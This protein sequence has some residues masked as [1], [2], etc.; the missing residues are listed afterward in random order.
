M[1]GRLKTQ[2]QIAWTRKRL[3]GK[4]SFGLGFW[5]FVCSVGWFLLSSFFG[6][7]TNTERTL[8]FHLK[9]LS[10]D[11]QLIHS[12]MTKQSFPL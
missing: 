12:Y 8:K 3:A 2:L 4:A 5:F 6:F 7:F 9:W 11:M 10:N 1:R